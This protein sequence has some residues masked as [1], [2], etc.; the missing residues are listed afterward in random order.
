MLVWLCGWIA[1]WLVWPAWVYRCAG[2]CVAVLLY[3]RVVARRVVVSLCVVVRASV[4]AYGNVFALKC[5]AVR[6]CG[7]GVFSCVAAHVLRAMCLCCSVWLSRSVAVRLRGC[8]TEAVSL[9]VAV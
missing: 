7:C 1:E 6:L 5:V 3:G 9:H 8:V 2:L 4:L